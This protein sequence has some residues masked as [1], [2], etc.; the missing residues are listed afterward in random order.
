VQLSWTAASGATGYNVK[1]S[2]TNGGPYANVNT[3]PVATTSFTNTGLTNGTAYF[4]VVT[5]V[6]AS[7]ESPVSTQASATPRAATGDTGGVT[8]T[9]TV[10]ANSPWFNEQQVRI[11]NTAPITALSITVVVQRTTGVSHSGQYNTVGGQ[12]QQSNSSTTS[13][14]TYQFTL[15]AGQTLSPATSRTFAVQTQGT[16]TVH[17]T[18]GDTYTVTYTTGGV[19][20]TQNGTF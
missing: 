9:P 8:A 18:T 14:I 6:N 3:S 10:T 16:G 4:Y 13:A 12:I 15:A 2:T 20:H 11:A 17:P 19:S 7:G 1:R 5:A